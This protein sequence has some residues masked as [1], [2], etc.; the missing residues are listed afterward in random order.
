[1][2]SLRERWEDRNTYIELGKLQSVRKLF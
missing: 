1:L 2:G